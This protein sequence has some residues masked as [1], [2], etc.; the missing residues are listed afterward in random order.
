[1]EKKVAGALQSNEKSILFLTSNEDYWEI[2][3]EVL[4][5]LENSGTK[6][7]TV[8]HFYAPLSEFHEKT[9]KPSAGK[10]FCVDLISSFLD[11]KKEETRECTFLDSPQ[12]LRSLT[13]IL[14]Q[15]INDGYS[16]LIDSAS[17]L[18]DYNG[19]EA[20][21]ELIEY[22]KHLASE[23]KDLKIVALS[24]EEEGDENISS[25]HEMFSRIVDLSE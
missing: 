21:K 8:V 3:A 20:V 10:I 16:I 14:E 6:K 25:M 1:M 17:L 22:L 24:V 18:L 2:L 19:H 11:L 12:E 7:T 4:G 15:K 9:A 5:A 23:N 13:G